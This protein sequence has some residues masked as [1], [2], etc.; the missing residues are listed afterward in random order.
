MQR[1][2]EQE[3]SGCPRSR[4]VGAKPDPLLVFRIDE[5]M[6]LGESTGGAELFPFTMSS[7]SPRGVMLAVS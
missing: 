1:G 7:L 5:Q 4:A 2:K 6:R 3:P